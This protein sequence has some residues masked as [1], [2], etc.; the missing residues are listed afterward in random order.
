MRVP[1]FP[2]LPFSA[3]AG[4]VTQA[5]SKT[6]SPQKY[7]LV[8]DHAAFRQTVR[9]FLPGMWVEVIEC[10]NAAEAVAACARHR[11]D[12]TLMD[13][14]LPG[15]DG[16]AATRSICSQNPKARVII[17]SQHDSTELR[18]AAH[19]AGAI[20]Y[21]RKD[22]L[23]DLPGIITSLLPNHTSNSNRGASS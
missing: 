3:H 13:I 5:A 2:R 1:L 22:E 7:L 14:Q 19:E 11:P 4:G 21:V 8:D 17:L 23:K 6:K 12:W 15:T 16:L 10:D 20:A 9:G 18:E